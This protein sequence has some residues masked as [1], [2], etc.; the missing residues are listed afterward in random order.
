M[1]KRTNKPLNI[2]RTALIRPHFSQL[3]IRF[4]PAQVLIPNNVGHENAGRISEAFRK[5]PCLIPNLLYNLL[6]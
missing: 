2:I 6:K 5:F 4:F 1:I 3:S